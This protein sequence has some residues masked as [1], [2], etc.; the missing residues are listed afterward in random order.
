MNNNN[1]IPNVF[2][3]NYLFDKKLITFDNFW[4]SEQ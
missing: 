3:F 1:N 4:V 2:G